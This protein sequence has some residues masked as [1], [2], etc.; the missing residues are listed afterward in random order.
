MSFFLCYTAGDVLAAIVCEVNNTFGDTHCYVLDTR[1][2][3]PPWREKK[4]TSR[5]S[6]RSMA[7]ITSPST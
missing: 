2:G 3:Q 4:A 5:R 1:D 6:S 7:P